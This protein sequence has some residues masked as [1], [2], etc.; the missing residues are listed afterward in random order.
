M[1]YKS[2]NPL[3]T[4]TVLNAGTKNAEFSKGTKVYFHFQTRA[5]DDNGTVIDDSRKMGK[6]MELVLGKK[7]RFEVWE[8]IVQMMA[9]KEVAKFKVDK[10]LVS[11]YPFVSKT[12]RDVGKPENQ[13][14]HHCCGL[15]LQNEGIGYAD[16]N[17]LIKEPC[18]LE[19]II[20][21]VSVISPEEYEKESWQMSEE[22]KL[23]AVPLLREQGNNLYRDKNYAA[24]AAKYAQ[25]IGMLEQ[26]MLSEKPG[27]E[28]W[29]ALDQMKVPLLLNFSQCKLLEKD[30]YAVIEHCNTVLKS[31]PGNVKA[32]FRRA[33]AHVG[34]WNPQ[35]AQ[36]DFDEAL[37]LNP[38]LNAV[39]K[40]EM[41]ALEELRKQKNE[42]DKAKLKGKMF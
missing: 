30:Y 10:S 18:D 38:S 26:L 11:G 17:Q 41:K 40:K 14:Q 39:I 12:L 23:S 28:E 25:A 5:C 34:A 31:D 35:E 20:E 22:E 4:K 42:E 3:I 1:D 33:K 32:L 9:V 2:P 27:D 13:R 7:F 29:K 24:A 8:T 19:F 37:K 36:D 6:P 16:L 15:T 21:L